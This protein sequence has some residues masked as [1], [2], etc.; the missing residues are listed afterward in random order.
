MTWRE[1][2]VTQWKDLKEILS[3][4]YDYGRVGNWVFRGQEDYSWAL[5]TSL[6]R[7]HID[8]NRRVAEE[9]LLYEFKGAAHH[10]IDFSGIPQNTLEW[11]ALMQHHG[12]PTRLLDFTKSPFVGCYFALEKYPRAKNPPLFGLLIQTG[13]TPRPY[14]T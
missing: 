6:E 10:Y 7:I 13:W 14:I 4:L 12:A 11:L 8:I 9:Y 3:K 2:T 5:S 1:E